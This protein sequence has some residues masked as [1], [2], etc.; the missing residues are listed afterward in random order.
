MNSE[1][2]LITFNQTTWGQMLLYQLMKGG[3]GY[4]TSIL[5]FSFLHYYALVHLCITAF[6]RFVT[7][8]LL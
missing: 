3:K 4:S 1:F 8:L 7:K 6:V 5:F 2:I